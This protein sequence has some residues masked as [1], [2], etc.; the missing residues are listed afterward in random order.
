MLAP[1]AS[2]NHAPRFTAPRSP[3]RASSRRQSIVPRTYTHDTDDSS[4]PYTT[5]DVP[6]TSMKTNDE[7]ASRKNNPPYVHADSAAHARN[8]GC[9]STARQFAASL[10]GRV[11][12]GSRAG[13]VS[14]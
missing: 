13:T 8:V 3:C 11:A 6:S 9:E 5:R 14:G 2:V 4:A 1:P 12:L 7:P 10:A